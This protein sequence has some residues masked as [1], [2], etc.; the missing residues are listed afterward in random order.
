MTF[1]ASDIF[2]T[3]YQEMII[4]GIRH[5]L[6]EYYTPEALCKKMV[7]KC[8]EVGERVLDSSCGSGTFLIECYKKIDDYFNLK[9]SVEPPPEWFR[10]INNIFGFDINPIAV[11]TT[12]ANLILY[13]K[14]HKEYLEKIEINIYLC[15]SINPVEFSIDQDI[16]LGSIYKFCVDLIDQEKKLN[17]PAEVLQKK[18]IRSFQHT[19]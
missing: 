16:D 18:N 12:K 2:R 1:E 8:L 15:N 17:I 19:R 7:N 5:Q 11:L 10:A 6:G 3:I 9:P 4:A 14:E 13:L